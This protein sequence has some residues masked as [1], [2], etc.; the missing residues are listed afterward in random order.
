MLVLILIHVIV[1]II[2]MLI[3]MIEMIKDIIMAV[4]VRRIIW[5]MMKLLIRLMT[6]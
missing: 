6:D 4:P 2:W 1:T 3:L 5:F